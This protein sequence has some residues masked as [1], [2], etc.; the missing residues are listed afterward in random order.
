M[1]IDNKKKIGEAVVPCLNRSKLVC[2]LRAA[3]LPLVLAILV[4]TIPLSVAYAQNTSQNASGANL[5]GSNLAKKESS[6]N[7]TVVKVTPDR[8]PL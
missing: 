2:I 3:V 7:K 8:L 1:A 6:M 4:I 5:S